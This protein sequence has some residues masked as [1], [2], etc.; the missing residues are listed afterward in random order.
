MRELCLRTRDLCLRPLFTIHCSLFTI[1]ANILKMKAYSTFARLIPVLLSK[2]L[3][4][5]ILVVSVLT[6]VGCGA[7][8]DKVAEEIIV[9]RIPPYFDAKLTMGE[10]HCVFS[11]WW[12]PASPVLT[13]KEVVDAC[14]GAP[15][16][17]D[18]V[19]LMVSLRDDNSIRLNHQEQG[20]LSNLNSVTVRLAEIFDERAKNRAYEPHT[21]NVEKSVMIKIDGKDRS[22]ADFYAVADAVKKSGSSSIILMLDGHLPGR[23]IEPV[24]VVRE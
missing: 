4:T 5:A 15:L 24:I 3:I 18:G 12:H 11:E 21:N 17:H 16:P 20:S 10:N 9:V 22:Y 14:K 2:K 1:S 23:I 8:K 13:D 6:L 19:P 7:Q